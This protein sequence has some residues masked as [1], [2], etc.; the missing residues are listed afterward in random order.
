MQLMLL[1]RRK[2]HLF[3]VLLA[4]SYTLTGSMELIWDQWVWSQ[5]FVVT[6]LHRASSSAATDSGTSAREPLKF[7][8][9]RR[10]TTFMAIG[11]GQ[12]TSHKEL[13]ATFYKELHNVCIQN[14]DIIVPYMRSE[15]NRQFMCDTWH[16]STSLYSTALSCTWNWLTWQDLM[17]CK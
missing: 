7:Q 11:L 17:H 16:C 10:M 12:S 5:V 2:N 8:T 9:K 6:S 3:L 13:A 14:L 4:E 1:M 15:L